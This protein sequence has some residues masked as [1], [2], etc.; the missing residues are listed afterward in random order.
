M[1]ISRIKKLLTTEMDFWRSYLGVS[2]QQIRRNVDIIMEM[3]IER[4]I[5]E[6]IE[7]R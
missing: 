1:S 2:R 5:V 7:R 4:D 3:G 6:E